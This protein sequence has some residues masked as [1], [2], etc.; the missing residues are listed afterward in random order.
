MRVQTRKVFTGRTDL[1]CCTVDVK[2]A[3]TVDFRQGRSEVGSDLSDKRCKSDT[4]L[5]QDSEMVWQSLMT[6]TNP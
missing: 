2:M 5:K 3:H 4:S 6:S 1:S